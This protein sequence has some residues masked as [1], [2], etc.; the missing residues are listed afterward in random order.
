MKAVFTAKV[1]SGYDDVV[2]ERYHFPAIYLAQVT[3]SLGDRIVYYEPRR[4]AGSEVGGRQ[5]Y[6]AIARVTDVEPDSLLR[7]HYYAKLVDY[8]D[9]DRPVPFRADGHFFEAQLQKEDG[10]TNKGAFGRSVRNIPDDEFDLIVAAGFAADLFDGSSE[11]STNVPGLEDIAQAEFDRRRVDVTGTR[12][13]RDRAF[14]RHVQDA[15]DRTCA[16]TGLRIINGGGK[17]EAQAAH[18]KPVSDDG[19][20]SIRNGL[21]LSGTL[22]WMFDRGLV[23]VDKGYRILLARKGVP[24]QI[25][26]L[27]NQTGQ[28]RLPDQTRFWPHEQF[29]RYHRE[30][31]FKD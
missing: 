3:N 20:D 16:M 1:G 21:A 24:D 23:S 14:A 15:Y 5:A 11:T 13:F 19:S 9:F 22:H 4:K 25:R 8:L 27:L 12:L 28:L 29:L 18:I 10:A 26:G 31:I 2:E 6:F 17:P 7:D 30:N